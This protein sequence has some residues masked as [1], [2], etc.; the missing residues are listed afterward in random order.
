MSVRPWE[1]APSR[2]VSLRELLRRL[3]EHGASLREAQ[4]DMARAELTRDVKVQVRRLGAVVA[5]ALLGLCGLQL[6]VV[7][8]VL[9]LATRLDAWLAAVIVSV[10]LLLAGAA[11]L[12]RARLAGRAPFL[13]NTRETLKEDLRW[14]GTQL[15]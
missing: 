14:L 3:A 9:G 6:L 11:L 7:A 15:R 13:E 5:A 12:A 4:V 1:S 2:E 10:P 8:L